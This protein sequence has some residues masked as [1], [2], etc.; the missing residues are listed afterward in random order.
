VDRREQQHVDGAVADELAEAVLAWRHLPEPVR[1]AILSSIQ[2]PLP[3]LTQLRAM[4][5]RVHV[6]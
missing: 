2:V 6:G 5:L 1:A 3:R 4:T